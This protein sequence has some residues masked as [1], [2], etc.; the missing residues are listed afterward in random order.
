MTRSTLIALTGALLLLAMPAAQAAPCLTVT[1]TG[2]Q[3]GPQAYKGQAGPGTLISYGDDADNCGAVRLQ[4]DA[5]RGTLLRL[6]QVKV[7]SSQLNA[8]FF[9]HMHN[10][11]SEGFIDLLMHR[12]MTYPKSPK[13]DVVCSDDAA[14]P[15]GHTISCRRFVAHIADTLMNAGEI[16]QRIAENK[17]RPKEGPVAHATVKIFAPKN[18]PQVVWSSGEVRV[19]AMRSTHIPGHASYRVDTPAGSVVVGGDAGNDKFAPPRPSS[20]SEQ[21]ELLAK[22]A[23]IIVHS[24]IHPV[25][26]PDRGSGMPAPIFYRQSAA[27]DLGAMAQRAGAKHLVLTHLIPPP[28]APSQGLWK[29]PGGPLTEADYR[30]AAQ[31][32]GFTGNIVVATDLAT[33]RLPAK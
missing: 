14:S 6:S 20:T 2:A 1:I 28:G 32:G 12:W 19:S 27:N 31:D 30:K 7:L 21:V 24:A 9:T 25:M 8:I 17:Q 33:L 15:L 3:G 11:H 16:A 26:A 23:D 13:I 29:V 4:F 10:D 5:G 22:G 18:E